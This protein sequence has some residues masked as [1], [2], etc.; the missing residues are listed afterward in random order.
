[1]REIAEKKM[2]DLNAN[3]VEAACACS[4][5]PPAPWA[6]RWWSKSDGRTASV[7]KAAYAEIDRDK[8][9]PLAEAVKMVKA[10]RQRQVRRDHRDRDESRHRSASRRP[11]GARRGQP[12]ATAPA[13]RVRVAVFAK[14]A[15]ADEAKAAGADVV[16]AED[17]AEKIQGGNIDFD[18]C[19]ATPD[20]MGL[21]GRLGKVL[22]PRGLMPNPKLGT[23][24][25]DVADAVKAAK[26]GQVE[27]RAEKA[28]I[29]HAGVGKASFSEEKLMENIKAFV[30]AINKAKPAGAKG[31]YL[32]RCR[33]ARPWAR[34]SSWISPAWPE[35]F[36]CPAHPPADAGPSLSRLRERVG[37]E[38]RRR[39][40]L[41]RLRAK[42][43]EY[44]VRDCWCFRVR[45]ELEGNRP[46]R[47][48]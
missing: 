27:F 34:A 41:R 28:G 26:G 1:M 5:A 8:F 18:R 24:T 43:G 42:Q 16:G 40:A 32:K 12:A 37:G 4:S 30:D 13:R 39:V 21:V 6:S 29:V 38:G 47:Q 20:M 2:K 3:D 7:S 17:L 31:T 11:D 25:M 35:K 33:S 23:V 14:G 45:P 15:K 19:I 36:C 44:P 46:H 22:G 10:T 48:S 9:Y